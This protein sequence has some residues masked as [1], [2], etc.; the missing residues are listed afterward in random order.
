MKILTLLSS[1]QD[2]PRIRGT[3]YLHPLRASALAGSSPHTR[4]KSVISNHGKL[5]SGIIPAYAGQ[6]VIAPDSCRTPRDHPRIRGTNSSFP[7]A[8]YHIRGS[9]P[10]TRDKF[11]ESFDVSYP[12]GIIPAY[13]GQIVDYIVVITCYRD[14][15]RIRGTN[16]MQVFNDLAEIG[17]S[18][19]T[20]DKFNKPITHLLAHRIIP[21]YAGQ[22]IY[23]SQIK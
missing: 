2:H 10:H 13:A 14:H 4:D 11:W 16:V 22:I 15:P 17:S 12:K 1:V 7:S 3:N 18:P 23:V 8:L 21:A 5:W 6:I 19:H 9:S 20:R